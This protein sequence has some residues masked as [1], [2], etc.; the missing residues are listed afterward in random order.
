ML[1]NLGNHDLQKIEELF[2]LA[3]DHKACSI[4]GKSA[5][6]QIKN[7]TARLKG[8][9]L[10]TDDS[11]ITYF[12]DLVTDPKVENLARRKSV[13]RVIN[14]AYGV[15]TQLAGNAASLEMYLV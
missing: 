2:L 3:V 10:L 12:D 6:T 15:G 4:S 11:L 9:N 1:T 7:M 8:A 5:K 14:A 13:C